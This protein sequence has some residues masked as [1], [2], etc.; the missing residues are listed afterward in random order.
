VRRAIGVNAIPFKI[1]RRVRP[2][3]LRSEDIPKILGETGW[4]YHSSQPD[5]TKVG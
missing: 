1:S 2:L 4:T 5:G 3:I